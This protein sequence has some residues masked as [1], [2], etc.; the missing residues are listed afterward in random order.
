MWPVDG[1]VGEN[2]AFYFRYDPQS[3]RMHR[4]Y[5]KSEKT[6]KE[7]RKKL[8]AIE[9]TILTKIPECKVASDQAYREA[10]LAI[11]FC[12]DIPPLPMEKVEQIVQ[13][14]K[15]AGAQAKISSIHVNGWFG[16]HDKLT[17]TTLLFKEVFHLSLDGINDQIIFVGDSPNDSPMFAYFPNSVGV[18]NVKRFEG[19]MECEPTW[20]T[21]LA[22]G[23]GFSE[24]VDM[25][26]EKD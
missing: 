25:L 5:V 24:M 16:D 18:A 13:C 15:N 1:V 7:D 9:K 26:L 4:R 6:R 17:S 12:E 19:I 11:D 21:K 14:F 22:G 23:S 8:K 2:G 3:K 10:D 20:V